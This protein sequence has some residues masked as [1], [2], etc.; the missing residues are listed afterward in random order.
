MDK[1]GGTDIAA[2]DDVQ[3]RDPDQ[4]QPVSCFGERPAVGK[5]SAPVT[6]VEISDFQ[7]PS[8]AASSRP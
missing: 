2:E 3:Q 1:R 8:A 6:I 7:C 4:A 5:A